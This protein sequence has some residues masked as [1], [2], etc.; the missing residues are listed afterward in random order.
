VFTFGQLH[1]VSTLFYGLKTL[2]VLAI[3]W[4]VAGEVSRRPSS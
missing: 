1:L 2:L 4:R 3:A